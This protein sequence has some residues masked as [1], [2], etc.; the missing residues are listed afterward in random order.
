MHMSGQES[1]SEDKNTERLPAVWARSPRPF[2]K[3]AGGKGQLLQRLEQCFPRSFS[4]YYEPF[5]GGGAVFFHLVER[6]P[7]F[8]AVLSD[9]NAELINAYNIVKSSVE[10]LI[11]QLKLH[12]AR[13]KLAPKKYY[14]QVRDEEPSDYVG[15]AARLIFLNKTCYNGLYRVNKMGK[16]NVPF[17][18]YKN[19]TICD[20]ENLLAVSQ[21]LRWS[22]AKLLAAD[23]KEATKEA[24]KGDFLYFDPPYQPVNATANFTGYTDMGF[25]FYDQVQLRDWFGELD[26]RGCRVLL[27]NS[28]KE[29]VRR[30]YRGYSVREVEV[31]R[32]ISCKA[33]R[34]KGHTEF[35]ISNYDGGPG[36]I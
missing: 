32:A 20:K 16:F 29:E 3:W 28:S 4:T 26:R 34:R 6:Q 22:D 10:K 7:P 19:P 21:L 5:L 23:Y 11:K 25:C 24:E 17:G 31:L 14:Y 35:I 30:I 36:A 9:I 18:R 33:D 8:N 27:S 1:Q 2:V 15:R 12:E 13:Y